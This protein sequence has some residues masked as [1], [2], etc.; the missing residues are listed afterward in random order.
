MSNYKFSL[1]VKKN[2]KNPSI[3]IQN[4]N[5]TCMLAN[6]DEMSNLYIEDW[7]STT[8]FWF[9]WQNGFRGKIFRN[10]PI[11]NKNCLWRPCLLMNRDKMSILYGGSSLDASYQVL[12]HLAKRFQRRRFLEIDQSETRTAC[13]GHAC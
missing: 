12:I 13:G 2:E 4:A 6:Q 1:F 3:K 10:W 8:K 11:R 9:I 5:L 7:P